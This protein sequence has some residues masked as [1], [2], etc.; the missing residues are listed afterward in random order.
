[1]HQLQSDRW[2]SRLDSAPDN[3]VAI[4][5]RNCFEFSR[6]IRHL[7]RNH[8]VSVDRLLAKRLVVKDQSN[9]I[10]IGHCHHLDGLTISPTPIPVWQEWEDRW[11]GNPL[12]LRNVEGRLGETAEVE[13][14][15]RRAGGWPFE[16][17][18]FAAVVESRPNKTAGEKGALVD[19]LPRPTMS[20]P[21]RLIF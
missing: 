3:F 20:A 2:S 18:W 16:W 6:L 13:A 15:K 8:L 11:M 7:P 1:G 17:L 12:G 14:T 10:G 4:F 9:F 19:V 5:R 21:P